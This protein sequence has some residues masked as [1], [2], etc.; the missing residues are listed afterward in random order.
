[1]PGGSQQR[2]CG[3]CVHV[4]RARIEALRASGAS[5]RTLGVKFGLSKDV[6][7]RHATQHVSSERLASL[8]VGP[9]RVADLANAAADESRRLT[10]PNGV[11][12]ALFSSEEPERLRGPQAGAAWCD[13]L[14]SWRNAQA[15]WDNLQFGLR[16]GKHPRQ[17]ISTT[18]KPTKLLRGLL[19]RA[20]Q[21]VTITRGTTYSNRENLAPTFFSQ[22]VRQYENTRLGKQE[23]LAEMLS[24]TPGAL[25]NIDM[26]ESGRKTKSEIPPMRRI[27][28]AIDPAVSVS[29]TSDATGIIV[30][31]LGTDN[32]GYVL[33]DAS[34]KHSPIE[35]A[36][37]AVAL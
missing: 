15:T 29:E 26:I 30:A 23:L 24:D 14:A 20:G 28:V 13:E 35:W 2:S 22:I 12:A 32:H 18:P 34:G 27:V 19:K 36:R 25:W 4:D 31:G 33:E 5:L 6:I 9:A 17:V 16:L 37:R 1:M 7:L 11:Q 3:V 21:D 10:W 8:L